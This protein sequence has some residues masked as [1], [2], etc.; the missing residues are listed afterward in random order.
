MYRMIDNELVI[1]DDRIAEGSAK[2]LLV[3]GLY[4]GRVKNWYDNCGYV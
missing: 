3:V 4:V 1:R 2:A